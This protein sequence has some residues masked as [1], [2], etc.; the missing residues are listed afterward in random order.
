MHACYITHRTAAPAL[1][2]LSRRLAACQTVR[3]CGFL[4]LF[5]AGFV[6]VLRL[7]WVIKTAALLLAS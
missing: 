4:A 1:V 5:A 7:L 3:D 6:A 2:R